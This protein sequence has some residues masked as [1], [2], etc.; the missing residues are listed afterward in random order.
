METSGYYHYKVSWKRST[1]PK[2]AQMGGDYM[3]PDLKTL[4]KILGRAEGITPGNTAEMCV[5]QMMP[6]GTVLEVLHRNPSGLVTTDFR[7]KKEA[8]RRTTV[9]TVSEEA[10][11]LKE[12]ERIIADT[13]KQ[14][15]PTKPRIRLPATGTR[16]VVGG[17]FYKAYEAL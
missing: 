2:A 16:Y 9:P 4:L 5:H 10:T 17:F 15:P 7:Q 1:H 6:D 13:K 12:V 14:P 3:A 11:V 8:V